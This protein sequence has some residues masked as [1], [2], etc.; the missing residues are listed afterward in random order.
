MAVRRATP[1]SAR[2]APT[3]LTY[4][5]P[6]TGTDEE[7]LRRA[8]RAALVRTEELR[9]DVLRATARAAALEEALAARGDAEVE[10]GL[11]TR[12]ATL[13]SRLRTADS[14]AVDHV[15]LGE[16]IDKYTVDNADGPPCLEIIPICQARCC[17]LSH[18]LTTQDLDEGVIKFDAERPYLI[19]HDADGHCTHLDRGTRGCGEYQHRPA[20]CRRYDCRNDPRVW[21]DYEA[22]VLAP[23]MPGDLPDSTLDLYER[24]LHRELSLPIE[25][26]AVRKPR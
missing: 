5:P 16:P 17:T 21:L 4:P 22:R 14:H 19:R 10:A 20:I 9:D 15:Q 23:T 1:G 18:A 26:A 7:E 24:A 6:V 25:A 13:L 3:R 12:T 8:L 11:E 2:H